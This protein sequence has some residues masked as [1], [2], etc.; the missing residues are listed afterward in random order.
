MSSSEASDSESDFADD[1]FE[2]PPVHVQREPSP[3][4][5]VPQTS[6]QRTAEYPLRDNPQYN[7]VRAA[8]AEQRITDIENDRDSLLRRLNELTEENETLRAENES[9]RAELATLLLPTK[10][11]L[12][13]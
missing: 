2:E 7:A 12:R 8:A 4:R 13:M 6:G 11:K 3:I 1:S 5:D 10:G 9:L